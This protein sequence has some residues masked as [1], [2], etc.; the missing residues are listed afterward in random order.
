VGVQLHLYQ[1]RYTPLYWY[2]CIGVWLHIVSAA[3]KSLVVVMALSCD[4]LTRRAVIM[5]R[6]SSESEAQRHADLADAKTFWGGS[7]QAKSNTSS[8][9]GGL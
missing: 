7:E 2:N 5:L 9:G 4:Y 1:L 6:T 3:P 8:A